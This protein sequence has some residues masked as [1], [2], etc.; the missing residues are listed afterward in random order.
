MQGAG[1]LVPAA[2]ELGVSCLQVLGYGE[3]LAI[4]CAKGCFPWK[5]EQG[6]S[7][8]EMKVCSLCE[9]M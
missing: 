1:G 2:L 9:L 5:R 3:E 6:F 4:P 7:Y 8:A